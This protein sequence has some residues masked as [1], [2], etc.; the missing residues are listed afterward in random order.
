MKATKKDQDNKEKFFA[1]ML[2]NK[3]KTR[4]REYRNN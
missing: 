4:K 3:G 1:T 2:Q